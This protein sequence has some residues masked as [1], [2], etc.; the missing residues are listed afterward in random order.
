[1]ANENEN[2]KRDKVHVNVGTIGHVDH[3]KTT[4]TAAITTVL[5]A[6][7]LAERKKYDEIDSNQEERERGITINTAHI[8]YSTEKRHYAHIDCPGH[9]DYIKNMITGA[10]QMD[11]A[12]LV[13]SGK[14]GPKPQTSEHLLLAKQVGVPSLIVFINK[15][16]FS[17]VTDDILELIELEVREL[18]KKYNFDYENTPIVTGSALKAIEE[19][20]PDY[21]GEKIYSKK[22][23]E[24][25]HLLDT[26]IKDPVRDINQPFLMPIENVLTISGRGTTV[27]GR[28]E[29]GQ[30]S[31]N[32]EVEIVG[33]GKESQKS[34]V[35][36]MKTFD[37]HLGTAIAGDNIGV[38]LRGI[39][40]ESVERG[41]ILCKPGSIKAYSIFESEIYLLT[42]KEGGRRTPVN[43]NYKPQFYFR[44]TDV[45]G[46]IEEFIGESAQNPFGQPGDLINVRIKLIKTVAIEVG[47]KFSVREGGRTIGAG[48]VLKIIE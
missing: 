1:M 27:T 43:A 46:S 17:D 5:H 29:R 18:L 26:Y 36:S 6:K 8:E 28:V 23:E 21:K 41:Q 40:K 10:S 2:L 14:D 34:V 48:H 20:E 38:L 37:Q 47:T 24:L 30:I 22:I 3:G 16:D 12:I 39:P 15:C 42:E 31:V 9:A 25:I 44:T 13:V 35:V 45:T 11:A 33:L 7:G 4:L 32:D 19:S